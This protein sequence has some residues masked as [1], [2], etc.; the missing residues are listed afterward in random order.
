MLVTDR[1]CYCDDQEKYQI[2]VIPKN[3]SNFEM[4]VEKKIFLIII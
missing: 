3:F 2:C 4:G 1:Y